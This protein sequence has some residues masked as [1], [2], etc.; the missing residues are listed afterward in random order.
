MLDLHVIS[1]GIEN[2]VVFNEAIYKGIRP[3]R[4]AKMNTCPSAKNGISADDPI[5]GRRLGGN[6]YN[7]L[8]ATN[9]YDKNVL[10]R[11]VVGATP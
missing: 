9:T 11:N 6:P 8:T 7:L 5:P 3:I 10:Q 1:N 4:I 2:G